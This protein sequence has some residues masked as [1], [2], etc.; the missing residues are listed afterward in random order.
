MRK[1]TLALRLTA[2][3]LFT[4]PLPAYVGPGAGFAFVGSFL[5]VFAAF[6]L[7]LFNLLTFPLRALV[8]LARRWRTL[9]HARF[10]RVVVVGFDGM[11]YQL[12][13]RFQKEG[14]KFPGFDRLAR[15]GC[16]LPLWSTEPP[17]SPVAWSTFATGA[18]P[19]KHNIFD[20]LAS[21]RRTYMPVL[22]GSEIIPPR[23]W[24][25]LGGWQVPLSSPLIELKRKGQSF[26]KLVAGRGIFAAVLRVP[27]TFPPEK[28]YGAMLAGL[29]TPDLRGSQ[30]S[31]TAY[32]AQEAAIS[33]AADGVAAKLDP[34]GEN[35]Y[36]GSIQ[37]PPHP[38]RR[39]GRL[40]TVPFRLRLA[41]EGRAELLV[42][43][44]TVALERGRLS[45]WVPLRFRA[46]LVSVHGIS[47]WVLTGTEPLQLYLSPIH[48]D[49]ARPAM[50][51]SHPRIL[52]VYLAKKFGPFATLGMAE[53][54]WAVN[55]RVLGEEQFVA[56]TW[57][58]HE[59]RER[60]FFDTLARVRHGL[61]VQVFEATDRM[62]HMFWKYLP[63]ETSPSPRPSR[64]P[65]VTGAVLDSYRRMDHLLN[66]L[67]PRLHRDDLLLVVSDHGFNA[68]HSSFHLNAWLHR[69]GYLALRPGCSV[70][71]KWYAD[72]DWSRTRAYGQGLN[73]LYLNL[74]GREREGIVEPGTAAEKLKGEIR[75]RLLR[76]KDPRNGVAPVQTAFLREELYRGP[77]VENAPDIVVGYR[78]GYRVSWESAVDEVGSETVTENTRMWSGDH[79]FSRDQ[80][81]GIFFCNRRVE[82]REP[83][84]ADIAPTVLAAFGIARP[85]YFDGHD[86]GVR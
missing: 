33:A 35:E 2:L 18:N 3:V 71:G 75:D 54:T 79:G 57:Q 34:V 47:Q 14:E 28:F 48:L 45:P 82:A 52:S 73:G 68:F 42:S 17:I 6:F 22:S 53:D 1:R 43:G 60:V 25:R 67:L 23:R 32:G 62:Q 81:P 38:F 80:V 16:F 77:Y 44:Q 46:G 27:Y 50:P 4:V 84:L 10:K 66:R 31:F 83:S 78:A 7:A 8:R 21:D 69:E 70:S 5:F 13:R 51:L 59:E 85:P 86:L 36:A 12:M 40:L 74:R 61:V 29:G 76:A 41:G 56:Q 26:W 20:F 63:G 15:D 72:V 49:P 30:G 55:E 24:L 65:K 39:D 37:G 58:A 19:G 9:R 64:D 11:D